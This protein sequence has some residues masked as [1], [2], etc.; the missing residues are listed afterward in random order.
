[1]QS[2]RPFRFRV[3]HTLRRWLCIFTRRL[4]RPFGQPF[5]YPSVISHV[6][7]SLCGLVAGASCSQLLSA[8]FHVSLRRPLLVSLTPNLPLTH[9]LSRRPLVGPL[10]FIVVAAILLVHLGGL[11]L[12]HLNLYDPL[13]RMPLEDAQGVPRCKPSQACARSSRWIA[14]GPL[15]PPST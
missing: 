3:A 4:R 1:M 12:Y 8:G 10:P 9:A 11:E 7:S 13:Q 6:R 15:Y 14:P 5:Y 2:V